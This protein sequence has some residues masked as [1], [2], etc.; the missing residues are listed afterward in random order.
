MM[1]D[2]NIHFHQ[3]TDQ[4]NRK[5]TNIRANLYQRANGSNSYR[6]FCLTAT[7]DTFFSISETLSKV[8]HMLDHKSSLKKLEQKEIV[9]CIFSDNCGAKMEINNLRKSRKYANAQRLIKTPLKEQWVT[10][11]IKRKIKYSWRQTKI[12]TQ[13]IKT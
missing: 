6:T 1:G 12:T 8:D 9:T 3:L 11:E 13:H 7:E 2:F 10:E 4:L 5:S